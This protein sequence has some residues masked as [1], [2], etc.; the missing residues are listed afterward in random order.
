[1]S[2]FHVVLLPVLLILTFAAGAIS[3]SPPAP[4]CLTSTTLQ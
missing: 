3:A 1:M 4:P 2:Y